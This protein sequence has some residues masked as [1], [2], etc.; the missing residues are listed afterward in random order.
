MQD[1]IFSDRREGALFWV[2]RSSFA[3]TCRRNQENVFE[4]E[5]NFLPCDA[6]IC[7]PSRRDHCRRFDVGEGG[8]WEWCDV[9]TVNFHAFYLYLCDT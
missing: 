1:L 6:R 2:I 4:F 7:L 5:L 9:V 8:G 3:M